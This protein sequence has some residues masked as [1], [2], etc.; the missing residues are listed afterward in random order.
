LKVSEIVLNAEARAAFGKKNNALRRG[1]VVP[2]HVYGLS[3]PSLALQSVEKDV[4]NTIKASGK[5]RR[6]A[7]D[8]NGQKERVDCLVR[9][10]DIHPVTGRLLH[11]DFLRVDADKAVEVEVPIK[12]A[13][14]ASAPVA[15]TGAVSIMLVLQT[16][17]IK[18]RAGA[19]PDAI[20]ADCGGMTKVSDTIRLGDLKLPSDSKLIGNPNLRVVSVQ[21]S[22]AA[23]AAKS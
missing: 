20:E 1:G 11:V 5:T 22:R 18:A 4:L 6:V 2:I 16:V 3:L 17:K 13:N 8:I 14:H 21:M 12:L 15:R 19:I 9:D 10:V 23:R 7:I